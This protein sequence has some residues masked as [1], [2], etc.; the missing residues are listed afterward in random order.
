MGGGV[1]IGL[2]G[3]DRCAWYH[4][5]IVLGWVSYGDDAMAL[6]G[7]KIDAVI[8]GWRA[9]DYRDSLFCLIFNPFLM[10]IAGISRSW[11]CI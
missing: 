6:G 4:G 5:Y 2:R 9:M 7:K 1:Y 8:A 3:A 11:R 10:R